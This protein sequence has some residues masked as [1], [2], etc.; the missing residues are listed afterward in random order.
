MR[1]IARVADPL[2]PSRRA[3]RARQRTPDARWRTPWRGSPGARPDRE[4]AP[5]AATGPRSASSGP[6]HRARRLGGRPAPPPPVLRRDP[7]RDPDLARARRL[8]HRRA[9]GPRIAPRAHRRSR[10]QGRARPWHAGLPDRRRPPPEPRHRPPRHRVPRPLPRPHPHHPARRPPRPR[11]PAHPRAHLLTADLAAPHRRPP[12][13]PA[14][15]H[16]PETAT[17]PAGVGD[18]IADTSWLATRRSRSSWRRNASTAGQPSR[19]N[20]TLS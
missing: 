16:R 1:S 11:R 9:R 18:H 20:T 17:I 19:L 3:L 14:P 13:S 6:D 15:P 10:R 4:R 2:A 8:P 12:T 5:H 7:P